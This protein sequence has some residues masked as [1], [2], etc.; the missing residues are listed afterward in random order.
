MYYPMK[1]LPL[2]PAWSLL[3]ATLLPALA[4]PPNV[5]MIY[6]DDQGYGDIG[7]QGAKGFSTPHLDR[8]AA[9]GMRFTDFYVA[10]PVCSA[11]RA[12]T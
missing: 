11:S 5:V 10:A 3:A 2:F 8:M 12:A 4:A 7:V 6:T 1:C 9:E